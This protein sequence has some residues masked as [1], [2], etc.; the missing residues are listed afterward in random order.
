MAAKHNPSQNNVRGIAAA[1]ASRI[2]DDPATDPVTD[3]VTIAKTA[4]TTG[5]GTAVAETTET[6][7]A[8]AETVD[9]RVTTQTTR[10]SRLPM[11]AQRTLAAIKA[12]SSP[13][14]RVVDE[15]VVVA[16]VTTTGRP[17][18]RWRPRTITI[19]TAKPPKRSL[20]PL[21]SHIDDAPLTSVTR[22]GAEDSV[23]PWNQ[24]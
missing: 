16:N 4:T 5:N 13:S 20:N 12:E 18:T 15:D 1:R 10:S 8:M 23:R 14:A 22:E 9:P 2:A 6:T 21:A 11:P 24:R 17:T 7:D 3:S 19:Q